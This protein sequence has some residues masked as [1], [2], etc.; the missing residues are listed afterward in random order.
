[1]REIPKIFEKHIVPDRLAL[2]YLSAVA[3]NGFIYH[4][5]C[6]EACL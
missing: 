3:C 6:E 1:M 2:R 4:E 5:L